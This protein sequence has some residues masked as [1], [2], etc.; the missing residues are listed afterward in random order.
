MATSRANMAAQLGGMGKLTE[1]RQR[2]GFVLM[3]LVV[4]RIG[5][6]IPTPGI[7]PSA[8]A[9]FFDQQSSTILG[10]FNMFSGGALERLSIFALGIMPYISAAIIMQLMSAVIPSLKELKK[11]EDKMRGKVMKLKEKLK[12]VFRKSES[13][14]AQEQK[15]EEEESSHL[16]KE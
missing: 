10:M 6:F 16:K 4:Y 8:M 7:D 14:N 11:E 13:P 3:A 1:L 15:E 5:T 2:L 12:K 9:R